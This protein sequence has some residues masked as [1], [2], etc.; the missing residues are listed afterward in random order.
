M[1]CWRDRL[2]VLVLRVLL[3]DEIMRGLSPQGGELEH[4]AAIWHQ[5]RGRFN[6]RQETHRLTAVIASAEEVYVSVCTKMT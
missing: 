6:D 4:V 2:W 1:P 5:S 3:I